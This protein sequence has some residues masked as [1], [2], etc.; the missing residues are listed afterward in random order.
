MSDIK[1]MY[2]T[3]MADHF[4]PEMTIS[5]GDQKLIYRKRTWKL[6]DAKGEVI[7]MGLRYG[8]N[9]GQEAAL[10][11]L[12]GGH[13]TL[14]ECHFLDPH[15]GLTSAIDE[16]AMVQAGKHPGKTNLTDLDN[17]LNIIKFLEKRPAAVILKHNNPCGAAWAESLAA[18]YDKA[19]MADR[20]AAFGGAAVFNRPLDKATAEMV[21]RNYL[22]VVAAPDFE[23]GTLN[24][25]KKAKD[26]RIIK[27]PR[28]ERLQHLVR[29][30]YVDFKC[31]IDGGIIA[32]Q[33]PLNAILKKEDF[34]PAVATYQGREYR[35]GRQPSE[36][37][38]EDLLFGWWVEQGIT[39]NSVIFVKD[40]CTVG[41]GTGEQDRVGVAEIAVFKAYTKYADALCFKQFGMPYK[42]LELEILQ[43]KRDASDKVVIDVETE[44]AKSGL[45]GAVMISDA[46]FPF[47]DGVDVGIRQGIAAV[48]HAGGSVRDYEVIQACNEAEPPVAMV[49]TGQRCFKH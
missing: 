7:E 1:A 23:A 19:N 30:R 31:L 5:F 18:A 20:I 32:Q 17:G 35:C 40:G 6:P 38:Y 22:E 21:A 37:E 14:G 12:V 13:L 48:A 9:P 33:S 10:Y 46:F 11:E 45:I 26:L 36:P 47:R 16:A 34:K 2:R 25:L 49:F 39:S 28:F 4:P 29:A 44:K 8:E 3:V 15:N 24:I 42:N 27:V 43:A 41:I